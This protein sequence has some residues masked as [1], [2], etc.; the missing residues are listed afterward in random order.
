MIPTFSVAQKSPGVPSTSLGSSSHASASPIHI[1]QETA[2]NIAD[3]FKG[4]GE[5]MKQVQ[6]GQPPPWG[7]NPKAPPSP[8]VESC[9]EVHSQSSESGSSNVTSPLI[10]ELPPAQSSII[11]DSPDTLT[12]ILQHIATEE[13]EKSRRKQE[14]LSSKLDREFS[15]QSTPS[16]GT[17]RTVSA[18]SSGGRSSSLDTSSS[19]STSVEDSYKRFTSAD[20]K[21]DRPNILSAI[22]K[23]ADDDIVY[24]PKIRKAKKKKTK[25]GINSN[26][27]FIKSYGKE[28]DSFLRGLCFSLTF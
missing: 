28:N 26:Q 14:D 2:H 6:D 22:T 18:D 15:F 3:A 9:K 1:L 20:I 17:S 27:V 21:P 11:L 24:S 12:V 4:V 8:D 25:P 19:R 13:D 16:A 23:P 5:K 10:E 7:P